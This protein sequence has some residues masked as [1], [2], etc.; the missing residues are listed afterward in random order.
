M[1]DKGMLI[2]QCDTDKTSDGSH[3]FAELYAIRSLLFIAL[4]RRYP[5]Q[6]FRSL[7]HNDGSFRDGMFIAGLILPTGKQVTLHM[8]EESWSLLHGIPT[9][10]RA[11]KWDGHGKQDSLNRLEDWLDREIKS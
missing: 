9:P 1:S 5:D 8:K 6:S 4:M 2:V 3:T 11:P 7:R 10:D